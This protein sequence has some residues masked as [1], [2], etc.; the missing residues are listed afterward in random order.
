M[1][2]RPSFPP[3]TRKNHQ[4][5][6]LLSLMET[7]IEK[8]GAIYISAPMTSGKRAAAWQQIKHGEIRL[9]RSRTRTKASYHRAVIEPNRAHARRL[10]KVLRNEVSRVVIDPT[11]LQDIP[12]WRQA[13]YLVFWGR[14]VA[15]FVEV[16]VLADLW[17]Y[18]DGASYEFLI[19]HT[20]GVKTV[21]EKKKP[22]TLEVGEQ[23]I[24]SA[25]EELRRW[26]IATSFLEGVMAELNR[27]RR[28]HGSKG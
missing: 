9:R 17:Q 27:L 23:L 13:D 16:V 20:R 5:A 6:I 25:I 24:R 2:V 22:V 8:R 12:G 1:R 18:S 7:V 26:R 11:A 21:D 14:V 15:T 3:R 4:I 10:A 28:C 19:A